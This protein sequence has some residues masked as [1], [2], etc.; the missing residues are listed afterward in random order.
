VS[1]IEE[2]ERFVAS[3]QPAMDELMGGLDPVLGRL[4]ATTSA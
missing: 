1:Q 3:M 2:T 4:S